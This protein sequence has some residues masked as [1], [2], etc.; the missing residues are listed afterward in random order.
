MDFEDVV[1][2]FR[3]LSI[4]EGLREISELLDNLIPA[5]PEVDFCIVQDMLEVLIS[6]V[7]E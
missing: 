1:A 4:A 5:N 7:E 2:Y 3:G 6:K